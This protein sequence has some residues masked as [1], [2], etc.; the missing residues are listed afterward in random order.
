MKT[1]FAAAA[2]T[3]CVALPVQAERIYALTS[4]DQIISFDSATPGILNSAQFVTG[5]QPAET[6][7]GIDFRPANGLLYGLGSSSRLYLINPTTGAATQVGSGQFSTLLSGTT[8]GF[9]FNP[10]VDRIRVVSDLDQNLRLNP[11]DGTVTAV[12]LALNYAAG[13]PFFGLSP[14]IN[15]AAYANNV[16]GALST[17]LY[18][19]DS[20]Q[21]SLAIQNPPNNGTL[22]TVGLLA[23]D[24]S[25]FNGFDI[26]GLG[27]IAYAATPAASGGPAADLYT[28]NLATGGATLRGHIGGAPDD[29]IIK[30]LTV[31]AV[32]EPG[33]GV[34]ALVGGLGL[35]MLRLRRRS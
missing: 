4:A 17:T 2:V 15:G 29:F 28:I 26:S 35:W 3:L 33:V 10:T 7:L 25:R 32:P 8:F 21:N 30:G 13:D 1:I 5:L 12:D 34:L 31:V 11:N 24:A 19:I 22:T 23:I 6:L 27:G 18:V 14:N 9:D 16:P 20:A